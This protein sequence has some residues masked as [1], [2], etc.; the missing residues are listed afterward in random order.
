MQKEL[1]HRDTSWDRKMH[2]SQA[3]K[4]GDT[5]Y[6]SGQVA[7]DD[8][9]NVIGVGD[10]GAQVR[11]AVRNIEA[12][13]KLTGACLRDVVKVTSFIVNRT[14]GSV[15]AYDRAFGEFFPGDCPASTLVEVRSLVLRELLVEI[16][17][18]AVIG[19]GS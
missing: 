4:V 7:L 12:I 6:V 10:V 13:L 5:I 2:Y 15:Q 19:A 17:S 1:I 3:V 16:E 8:A 9:G 18:I 14:P 11:Q